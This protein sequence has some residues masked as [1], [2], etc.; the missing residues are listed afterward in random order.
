MLLPLRVFSV[1]RSTAEALAGPLR[2]L[3]RKNMSRDKYC[4]SELVH[5][6]DENN[7]KPRQQKRILVPLGV[8]FK[9]SDEHP[10]LFIWEFPPPPTAAPSTDSSLSFVVYNVEN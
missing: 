7:C 5:L 8:L 1:K 9:I 4:V 6:R 2:L 3:R 10:L